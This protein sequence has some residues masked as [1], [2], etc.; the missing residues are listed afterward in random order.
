MW[1]TPDAAS[2]TI[3]LLVT[4]PRWHEVWTGR[5]FPSNPASAAPVAQDRVGSLL[6]GK[7]RWWELRPEAHD[8]RLSQEVLEALDAAC[9]QFFPQYGS[10]GDLLARLD[11]GRPLP[12][13]APGPL[14]HATLLVAAGR[15][16][17]A[18][19]AVDDL[20]ATQPDWQAVRAVAERL[21]LS[22]AV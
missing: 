16:L 8:E 17:E 20:G 9:D 3:N 5:P 7:D 12:G 21:G 6:Y 4:W 14:V 15:L 22:G 19:R 1:N 13:L 2:F 10:S 11:S 18:R